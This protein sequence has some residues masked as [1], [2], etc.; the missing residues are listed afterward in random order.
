MTITMGMIIKRKRGGVPIEGHHLICFKCG[1]N[2]I[3]SDLVRH[4]EKQTSKVMHCVCEEC[5][6]PLR[7]GVTRRGFYVLSNQGAYR[8][9]P[10]TWDDVLAEMPVKMSDKLVSWFRD[11]YHPPRKKLNENNSNTN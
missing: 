7:I 11:N 5:K 9:R 2:H 3:N 6:Y 1:H 10:K 4:Y 8:Y